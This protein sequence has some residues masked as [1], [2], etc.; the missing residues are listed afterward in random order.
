MKTSKII[1]L[2]TIIIVLTACKKEEEINRTDNAVK[3]GIDLPGS[4]QNPAF[5][6][7][8][9][10][11]VFTHFRKGYNKI[12]SDLYTFNLE[13]K[14]LKPLVVDGNSNV[15]LPGEC[16]N[17]NL[18]SII[19]SSERDPHDEVFYISETGTTGDET[20]ITSRTDS[21]AFEPTFSPDGQ[22]IVFESHKYDEEKNGMVVKYK[23]DGSSGYIY[24]TSFGED[25]KQPNWAP[26]GDK[27]L[28]Q[29]EENGQWDIWIMDT[30]GSNKTKITNFE[31]SK[32]DAAFTHDGQSII[33]SSENSETELAN[34]YKVSIS[35]GSPVRLTNYSGYDGAPSISPD[36]KTLIFES[37]DKD[38]DKSKGAS[39]WMLNL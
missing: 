33:F 3:L 18:N 8:G 12:P 5:S 25:C 1:F 24:L 36:G 39:L 32:T 16:W 15:N 37:T 19:F 31:G 28:Y 26:A 2:I 6:P 7:D 34:I 4:I 27:I 22:W 23:L 30:D 10:T 21:V 38:P 11:I 17:D 29:K 20:Q 35:G 9:K 14:V 13:T